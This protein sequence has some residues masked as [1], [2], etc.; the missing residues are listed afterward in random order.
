[1]Y[2]RD[3]DKIGKVGQIWDDGSGRP[4]WASVKTGLFGLNESLVPLQEADLQGDHLVVPFEKAKVKDAPN[5]DAS[6]DEPLTQDD[7]EKLYEYYGMSWQ[8]SSNAYQA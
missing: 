5:V 7:V 8:D 4:A 3:G 6:H 1:M 2:D